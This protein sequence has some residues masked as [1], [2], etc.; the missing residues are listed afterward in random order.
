MV[1]KL[2]PGAVVPPPKILDTPLS[3]AI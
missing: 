3:H 2:E 1:D